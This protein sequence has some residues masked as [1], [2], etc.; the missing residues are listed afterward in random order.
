MPEQLD[1]LL[2][3]RDQMGRLLR[4]IVGLASDL[5]LDATLRRIVTAAIEL[6]G[7][8]YGA[9]G[10]LGPDGAL[11]SFLHSG[12]DKATADRIGHLPVGKG[13]LGVLLDN[14]E[15]L[16]LD[17]LAAHPAAVGF[18]E[19]HP[20]MRTFLGVPITIRHNL[21]GSLYLSEPKTRSTFSESDENVARALASA[22]AVAIDNARL[23]D[24]MRATAKWMEASRAI[25]TAL[26]SEHHRGANPMQMIA[27]RVRELTDADQA[28]VLVPTD[29]ELPADEVQTL[30]ISTAVGPLADRLLGQEVPVE[31]STTGG[32]FRSG[33]PLITESFQH[34]IQSFSDVGRRHAIVIPLRARQSVLGVLA[35]ARNESDSPFDPSH[36][37]MMSDFADHAAVALTL[38]ESQ[39][40]TRELS[41][42]ADRERIAH[43]LHDHVIQRLFAAGMDLQGTIARSRSV[44]INHRL[45]RTVDD[46]QATIE[47]IRTTIF[48]LQSRTEAAG[49]FRRQVQNGIAELTDDRDIKTTVRMSG[50]LTVVSDELAEHATAVVIEA[51]SNAVRHSGAEHLTVEI[52]VADEL[53]IDITDDGC[54]IDPA[55]QRRSGLANFEHRAHL[56]G[57]SCDISGVAGGG[58]HVRWVAT[59]AIR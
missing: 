16:R 18:P 28:I 53:T 41:L 50:P 2:H 47:E 1:E 26:V 23:F 58:T 27:E 15:P 20:P 4:V 10:V 55:N 57:G 46:L 9:L 19:H 49:G 38:T 59:L 11:A 51:V 33:V 3:A 40:Q 14:P 45:N 24:R 21:F 54:G 13:V 17:D 44:E 37:E 5:D 42:I 31:G 35:V 39:E 29:T 30:V 12:I 34:P 22:A 48:S 32:V 7:A 56:V 52:D 8:R 43:D 36:L 6:T 25:T